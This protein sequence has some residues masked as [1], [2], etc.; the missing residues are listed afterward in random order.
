[1]RPVTRVI[2]VVDLVGS[3][4]MRVSHGD[5]IA[6]RFQVRFSAVVADA[7]TAAGGRLIED[8][9]DGFLSSFDSANAALDAASSIRDHL[10]GSGVGETPAAS[11]R[12]GIAAGDVIERGREMYGLPVVVAARLEGLAAPG[13]VVC[14]D[15]VRA[16]AGSRA[17]VRFTDGRSAELD[18]LPDPVDLWTVES[19]RPDGD[20]VEPR[21]VTAT[22][23]RLP[24]PGGELIG[25]DE[26]LRRLRASVAE[27]PLTTITG[28]GGV[29]KTR[30]ALELAATVGGDW[31]DGAWFVPLESATDLDDVL[32][33]VSRAMALPLPGPDGVD[34]L[35]S[36]LSTSEA[37]VVLDNCEQ[38]TGP[39]G[40]VAAAVADRARGVRI[41]ATSR[42]PLGLR[43]EWVS[44]LGPLDVPAPG[45]GPAELF[46][47]AS[48]ALFVDR[49]ETGR[50]RPVLEGDELEALADVVRRL[51]G[52]PLAIELAAARL[53]VLR[54]TEMAARADDLVALLAGRE[55]DRPDRHRTLDATV[56]W[57]VAALS[58]DQRRVL[59]GVA[60]FAGGATVDGVA[61]VCPG[62]GSELIDRLAELVDASLIQRDEAGRFTMLGPIRDTVLRR[63]DLA[64][65]CA[66][67]R[68]RHLDYYSAVAREHGPLLQ[69]QESQLA[70][71]AEEDQNLGL[72]LDWA[73][74]SGKAQALS[75]AGDLGLYWVL[76]GRADEGDRRFSEILATP[77]DVEPPLLAR[78]M[79]NAAMAAAL[80]GRYSRSEQLLLAARALYSELDRPRSIAYCDVWLARNAVVQCHFGHLEVAA[81]DLAL[82]RLERSVKTLDAAGDRAG[83]LLAHPYRGW[84][85]LLQGDRAAA[86]RLT[87]ELAARAQSG[88]GNLVA[89]YAVA[90]CGFLR[91]MLGQLDAAAADIDH[92]MAALEQT[93]DTQNQLIV[94][95]VDIALR[96]RRGETARERSAARGVVGCLERCQSSEWQ[97]LAL[98]M[99]AHAVAGAGDWDTAARVVAF[100]EREH[101]MWRMA[102]RNTGVEPATILE[103]AWA[104]GANAAPA[105]SRVDAARLMRRSLDEAGS[106][107]P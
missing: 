96:H 35:A 80:G 17:E 102:M 71:F 50:S 76:S 67:A 97:A 59:A 64:A 24:D 20:R 93:G 88:R 63:D 33:A 106:L 11:V 54:P 94:G 57:S 92:A 10:T 61:A 85:R 21:V 81:L 73:R 84:A 70:R 86:A 101:P 104:G 19:T 78:S 43:R 40:L 100:M 9:G 27:Q 99:S 47:N 77:G 38:V 49:S 41:V 66:D 87:E 44:P 68:R 7:T 53:N 22:N 51:D 83:S 5:A 16:L 25:R 60:V 42:Q 39:V 6:D 34:G 82:D 28:P 26:E 58:P 1:M 37:L 31:R 103:H 23:G 30:L 55:Q 74:R 90:H 46:D 72:A 45:L 89:V 14:T 3:T 12:M 18:G 62:L 8:R 2:L 15:V 36:A 13:E 91:S 56:A 79:R 105:R 95:C 69:T 29:G 4:A 107:D 75:L 98:A 52:L 65:A 32:G 48:I